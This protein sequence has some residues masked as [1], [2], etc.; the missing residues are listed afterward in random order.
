MAAERFSPFFQDLYA[1]L[2][3]NEES[4]RS[5]NKS[6]RYLEYSKR[7]EAAA[8]S[9]TVPTPSLSWKMQLRDER[10]GHMGKSDASW[11]HLPPCLLAPAQPHNP[12]LYR[13]QKT[14]YSSS[15]VLAR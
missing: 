15:R 8:M 5:M 1:A 9:Q 2:G 4:Q 3:F 6:S 11:L 12:P 13:E 14:I 7:R 10:R